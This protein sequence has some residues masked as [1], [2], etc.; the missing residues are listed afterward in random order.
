MASSLFDEIVAPAAPGKSLPTTWG[1]RPMES[2]TYLFLNRCFFFSEYRSI[3]SRHKRLKWNGLPSTNSGIYPL[4][5]PLTKRLVTVGFNPTTKKLQISPQPQIRRLS[6]S[7]RSP[8]HTLLVS[9]TF[10][11]QPASIHHGPQPACLY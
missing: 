1:A 9:S 4:N 11:G 6:S 8:W 5:L 2:H 7:V 10:A 3:A